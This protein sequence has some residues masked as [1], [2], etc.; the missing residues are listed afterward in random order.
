MHNIQTT[1]F[2]ENY[3]HNIGFNDISFDDNLDIETNN[4]L[5]HFLYIGLTFELAFDFDVAIQL[6]L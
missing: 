2:L 4:E 3:F 1:V 5:N 6:D